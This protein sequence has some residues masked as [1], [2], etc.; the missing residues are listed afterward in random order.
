MN[1]GLLSQIQAP[2]PRGNTVH[3]LKEIFGEDEKKALKKKQSKEALQNGQNSNSDNMMIPEGQGSKSSNSQ[4]GMSRFQKDK[5][6]FWSGFLTKCKKNRLGVDSYLLA[7]EDGFVNDLLDSYLNISHKTTFDEVLGKTAL[8][9][10]AF[11]PTNPLNKKVYSEYYGY[12]REKKIAGIVNHLKH[13]SK[14]LHILLYVVPYCEEFKNIAPFAE[15]GQLIGVI[16]PFQKNI[17]ETQDGNT[18]TKKDELLEEPDPEASKK[19][20]PKFVPEEMLESDS[21]TESGSMS[22]SHSS[23]G[24]DDSSKQSRASEDK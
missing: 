10:V 19:V 2:I 24:D 1:G 12:F 13:K 22:P 7:G 8:A 11:L 21:P 5:S 3:M 4:N 18:S 23:Y 6:Y 20:I 15:D 17:G 9:V 16:T 14:P